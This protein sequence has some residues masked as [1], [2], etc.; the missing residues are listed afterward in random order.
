MTSS[1]HLPARVVERGSSRLVAYDHG[2]H[3]AS[4]EVDGRPVVWL[5][6]NAVLDGSAPLRGGIPLCFP[7]F[8]TGPHGGLSPSHGVVRTASWR[9]AT[10]AGDEVWAWDLDSADI[11]GAPGQEHLPGPFTLRYAVSLPRYAVAPQLSVALTVSNPASTPLRVEAAL[12]TYLAVRDVQRTMVTGLDG[13]AYFDKVTQEHLRQDGP[14]RP[15]GPIDNVYDATGTPYLSVDDGG[16]VI[17]VRSEGATQSVIWNPGAAGA[18]SMSD[19]G[20]DEW[21]SF[22]CVESAFTGDRAVTIPGLESHRLGST[23]TVRQDTV[24]P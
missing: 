19:L 20:D 23:I 15:D 24:A 14:V 13:A 11:S 9:P 4:W 5:S 2:A 18:S 6:E 21:R 7:W 17:D 8:A 10:V 16:R 12:H 3:L 1:Q 22:V